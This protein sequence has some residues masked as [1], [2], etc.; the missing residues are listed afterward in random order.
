MKEILN[1][2]LNSMP[3]STNLGPNIEIDSSTKCTP[4]LPSISRRSKQSEIVLSVKITKINCLN[5]R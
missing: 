2:I 1:H 5:F 3:I 4:L